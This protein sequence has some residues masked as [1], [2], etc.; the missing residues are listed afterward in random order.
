[1]AAQIVDR[2]D[3]SFTIQITVPSKDSMLDAEE[4]IQQALN[5]A[6]VAATTEALERF[7]TDGKPIQVG[8]T[9]LTSKGRLLKQ[10]QTPYGV[11]AVKR[12]VYQSSK[13]GPTFCPLDQAARIV[14]SST[15]R[16]AKMV[17]HKYAESGSA[18]VYR[19]GCPGP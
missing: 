1:M 11:A 17:A 16:F 3:R 9:R 10:Y 18:R 13:G 4:A 14:V 6:G 8:T 2:S 12:H 19:C 15:P 5:Q 7:D